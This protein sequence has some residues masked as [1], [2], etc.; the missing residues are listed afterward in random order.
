VTRLSRQVEPEQLDALPTGDPAAIRSRRDLQSLN[1]VMGQ[2]VAIARLLEAHGATTWMRRL[3]DLGG[4][5]GTLL[6]QV[7]RRLPSRC[8][9]VQGVV[10]DRQ[11][12]VS[13][14]TR[15]KFTELGWGIDSAITDVFEWLTQA[16]PQEGTVIMANLFLHHFRDAPLGALLREI[17]A[18]T[19]LFVAC[20]P[21]RSRL[22]LG[23][24]RLVGWIGC[25]AV[26]QHDATVSVR[27]AFNGHE[28]STLWPAGDDWSTGEGPTGLFSH[29]FVAHRRGGPGPGPSP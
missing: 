16:P 4:G 13:A 20:E 19:D 1:L 12:L 17:S 29:Y 6:L 10:V 27:A 23:A 2:P 14:G 15:Q 22:A 11:S 18:K 21:R 7:A 8:R 3:V 28:I 9:G 26:T 25:N 5:D 24:S